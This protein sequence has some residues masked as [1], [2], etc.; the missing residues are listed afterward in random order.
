[1]S[2][3]TANSTGAATRARRFAGWPTRARQQALAPRLDE[4]TELTGIEVEMEA[5]PLDT[6]RQRLQTEMQ[7]GSTDVDVFMT[8]PLQEGE[9]LSR[10][11]WYDDLQQYIDNPAMTSPDYDF[12]DFGEEIIEGHVFDGELT[13]IPTDLEV[14]MLYYRTDI[15]DEHGVDVPTTL[16]ELEA[17]AAQIDDPDGVRAY[18]NRGRTAAAVT[19]LSTFLYNF[20]ADFVDENGQAA[21]NTPEGIEAF[22]YYGRMIRDYGPPGAVNNSWEEVMALFQQG[23]V[24]MYVEASAHMQW[25]V[26]PDES[27]VAEN[28]GAAP[29]P[30]GLGGEWQSC[31]GWSLGINSNTE[32][33]GPAWYFIQWATSPDT[34]ADIQVN[35]LV[36]GGRES[37]PFADD[38]P[39]DWVDAFRESLA[40]ARPQLPAVAE[41][42]EV[43][44]VIGA[45]VVEAIQGGDVAAAVERAENEFNSIVTR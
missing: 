25:L 27:R 38:A 7:A 4:F 17:V 29:V 31:F 2:W 32:K 12:D 34:V 45:A 43:R 41:V 11:G 18:T 5:F 16:E 6:F 9:R 37:T 13:S 22:D 8:A 39:E 42:T 30:A 24:A 28:V 3:K 33:K 10:A 35:D 21:F 36:P 44:D 1:M 19:K 20:G 14:D 23:E 40:V 15:F 26:D